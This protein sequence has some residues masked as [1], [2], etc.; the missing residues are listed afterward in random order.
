M[1]LEGRALC[2]LYHSSRG[3]TGRGEAGGTGRCLGDKARDSGDPMLRGIGQ[4]NDKALS[5]GKVTVRGDYPGRGDR[6][7]DGDP[8]RP[9]NV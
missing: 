6:A 2:S 8:A 5:T 4:N 1:A 3:F 7:V 9:L